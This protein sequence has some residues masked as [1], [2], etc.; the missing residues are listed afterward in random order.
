MSQIDLELYD[1]LKGRF[2]ELDPFDLVESLIR[3][4]RSIRVHVKVVLRAYIDI[5]VDGVLLFPSLIDKDTQ[6]AITV[7]ARASIHRSLDPV[8]TSDGLRQFMSTKC[9][10]IGYDNYDNDTIGSL[11]KRWF[12]RYPYV[13][14]SSVLREFLDSSGPARGLPDAIMS[15]IFEYIRVPATMDRVLAPL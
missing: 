6:A 11:A 10:A 8:V 13:V 5:E 15:K 4:S 12:S 9:G 2:H 1:I 3:P 14:A 7:L